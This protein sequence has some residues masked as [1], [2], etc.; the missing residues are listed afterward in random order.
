MGDSAWK[1]VEVLKKLRAI[2][3]LVDSTLRYSIDHSLNQLLPISQNPLKSF[4]TR[5]NSVV[6]FP[7]DDK[8]TI[9]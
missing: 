9:T 6:S 8:I 3:P 4:A 7:N 1:D 2:K 5:I